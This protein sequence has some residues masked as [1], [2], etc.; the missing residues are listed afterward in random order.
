[1]SDVYSQQS[2]EELEE[3][4]EEIK[5]ALDNAKQ[6]DLAKALSNQLTELRTA[7]AKKRAA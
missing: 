2:A 6:A 4:I 7:L 5:T 3:Q 1:M